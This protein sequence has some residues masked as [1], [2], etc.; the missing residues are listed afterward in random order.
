[1]KPD[2]DFVLRPNQ[3]EKF[4]S[5]NGE[6]LL[7]SI[8][9]ELLADK[10]YSSEENLANNVAKVITER[11]KGL[12]LSH[13]KYIVQVTM[14]EQYG[15]GLNIASQCVWDAD[16]DGMAKYFYTNDSLWCSMVVF[17]IFH[18]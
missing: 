6:A 1:M 17:A 16:C 8:A 5:L 15:Q 11:L 4:R 18:Y 14:G 2:R 9:V 3:K 12:D 13:Y 7:R 10:I